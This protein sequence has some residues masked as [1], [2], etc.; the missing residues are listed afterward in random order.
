MYDNELIK[1]L[2]EDPNNGLKLLMKKYTGLVCAVVKGKFA[3]FP[4]FS[5]EDI[6]E[7][8]SDVFCE[9]Y[10]NVDKFDHEKGSVKAFLCAVAKN[11]AID[12]IRKRGALCEQISIDDEESG[13]QFAGEFLLEEEI[14]TEELKDALINEINVLGEPDREIIVRKFY[15]AEPSKYIAKKLGLTVSAVDTRAHRALKKL[16][17]KLGGYML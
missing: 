3:S 11:K 17:E 6:E 2:R 9:F 16:K 15:F 12:E 1:M 5:A 4:C 7:C 8:I 13:M 14:V 10:N